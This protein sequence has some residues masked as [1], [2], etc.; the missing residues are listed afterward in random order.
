ML[1]RIVGALSFVI[2]ATAIALLRPRVAGVLVT[3][4]PPFGSVVGL[5]LKALKRVPFV[6]WVQDL[7]PDQS[8]ALGIKSERDLRVKLLRKLNLI[9]FNRASSVIVLDEFM[10]ERLRAH[11]DVNPNEVEVIPLWARETHVT[12]FRNGSENLYRRELGISEEQTVF[13]YAGNHRPFGLMDPFL[14]AAESLRDDP[15]LVFLFAGGGLGKPDVERFCG[16]RNLPNVRFLPYQPEE[17]L[18]ELLAA[19]DVHLA[20]MDEDL[21]G[22]THPCKVYNSLAARRPIVYVGPEPSHIS[23]LVKRFDVGWVVPPSE[24]SGLVRLMASLANGD[25]GQIAIKGSNGEHVVGNGLG[26]GSLLPR[27]CDLIQGE[28]DFSRNDSMARQR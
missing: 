18:A 22:I 19:G 27:V 25:H 5:I 26:Q 13:L 16:E 10:R 9:A 17:R 15:N 2:Q 24:S 8:L 12:P 11:Y 7:N 1:V 23:H 4:A 20:A 6:V 28:L 3:T 21:V 14:T